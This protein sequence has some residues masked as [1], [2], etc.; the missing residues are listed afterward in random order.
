MKKMMLCFLTACCA[1]IF[2]LSA[3]AYIDP[4]V[5]SGLA[6][7]VAGVAVACGAAFF[8]I[9]RRL[10][11]KVSKTLGIDENAGKEVEDE[12]AISEEAE[13]EIEADKK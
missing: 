13:A 1:V 11:S 6:T 12:L 10:R 9:W 2:Q 4:S 7:A 8:V 5:V 3:F